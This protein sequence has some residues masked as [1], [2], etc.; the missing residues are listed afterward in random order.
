MTSKCGYFIAVIRVV[1]FLSLATTTRLVPA[2]TDTRLPIPSQEDVAKAQELIR[3]AYQTELQ[4][5]MEARE[6]APLLGQLRSAADATDDPVRKYALLLE[7]REIASQFDDA[8]ATLAFVDRLSEVFK[9]DALLERSQVQEKL[10]GPRIVPDLPLLKEAEITATKAAAEQRYDIAHKSATLAVSIAQAIDRAQKAAVR[11]GQRKPAVHVIV[12]DIDGPNLIRATRDLQARLQR[13]SKLYEAYQEARLVLDTRPDDAAANAAAANYLCFV[14]GD[15]DQGLRHLAVSNTP[16]LS[17]LAKEEVRLLHAALPAADDVFSLAGKW[18]I[19]SETI[20][21]P[22]SAPEMLKLHAAGL[23][24]RVIAE[25]SD[26]LKVKVALMRLDDSGLSVPANEPHIIPLITNGRILEKTS[27]SD[28][29]KEHNG[30][31]EAQ[32][33]IR[34]K[35]WN[36]PDPSRLVFARLLG[37]DD[38]VLTLEVSSENNQGTAACLGIRA[39]QAGKTFGPKGVGHFGLA[40]TGAEG[41]LFLVQAKDSR[42]LEP[43]RKYQMAIQRRG[44]ILTRWVDGDAVTTVKLT[45]PNLGEFF[46]RPWRGHIRIFN[47]TLTYPRRSEN[48]EN[49]AAPIDDQSGDTASPEAVAEGPVSGSLFVSCDDKV[50]IYFGSRLVGRSSQWGQLVGIPLTLSPQDEVRF[51]AESPNG[52]VP[53]GIAWLFVSDDKKRFIA[54]DPANT[55]GMRGTADEDT[56][57]GECVE[58]KHWVSESLV[59]RLDAEGVGEGFTVKSV[60]PRILDATVRKMLVA[61]YRWR[62]DP[63][64]FRYWK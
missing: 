20:K 62:F 17:T 46:A 59:K 47:A 63:A 37:T 14:T 21:T 10:A 39:K 38:F 16:P 45:D 22:D 36:A 54:S 12:S 48:A 31:C 7:A 43:G 4:A 35:S 56:E 23:Y 8:E 58:G 55:S 33:H 51:V 30:F 27:Q 44:N 13:E 3:V 24:Q 34:G 25:L 11:P 5:A 61:S 50:A 18:W 28:R 60:E 52:E 42:V 2:E 40:H 6:P 19:A 64:D 9:I 53:A 32:G 57:F 49:G 29:W 26:P 1:A 15:W 41:G